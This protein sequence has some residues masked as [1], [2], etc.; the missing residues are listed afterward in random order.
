MPVIQH[1]N[2]FMIF[3][4]GTTLLQNTCFINRN[5]LNIKTVAFGSY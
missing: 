5:A 1:V 3:V 2:N 4:N